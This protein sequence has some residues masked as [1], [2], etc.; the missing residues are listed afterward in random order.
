M[1]ATPEA[2]ATIASQWL[3]RFERALAQVDAAS[4]ANLFHRDSHWRDVL[5]L[6]WSITTVNGADALLGQL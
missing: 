3:A 6:T 2:L 5:A 4:L 1:P